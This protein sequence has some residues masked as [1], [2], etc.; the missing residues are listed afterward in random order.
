METPTISQ[1][2]L[3]VFPLQ[4]I[5]LGDNIYRDLDGE[6]YLDL[7]RRFHVISIRGNEYIYVLCDCK[8]KQYLNSYH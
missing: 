4:Q 8:R 3:W 2:I 1:Y 6:I 5:T 7:C